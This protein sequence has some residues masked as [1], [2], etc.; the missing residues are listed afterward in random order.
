MKR[1]E[2][3]NNR[4]AAKIIEATKDDPI[5]KTTFEDVAKLDS[6]GNHRYT[7]WLCRIT[8]AKKLKLEDHYKVPKA[9]DSFK[10]FANLL[11]K[12]GLSTD[13]NAYENLS[14]VMSAVL[15]YEIMREEGDLVGKNEEL[16]QASE[17]ARSESVDFFESDQWRI[18]VP[19]T[20]E[21][22]V[23][24]GRSTRWCTAATESDNA[25]K[26]YYDGNR[27]FLYIFFDKKNNTK[28][29]YSN[30]D[31]NIADAAD[32]YMDFSDCIQQFID[33]V[34]FELFF[35][36]AFSDLEIGFIDMSV[37]QKSHMAFLASPLMTEI[38]KS[39]GQAG[40]AQFQELLSHYYDKCTA[41]DKL[42]L[43]TLFKKAI[44]NDTIGT[45][46]S[47]ACFFDSY[48]KTK[49]KIGD[50][51]DLNHLECLSAIAGSGW[52]IKDLSEEQME[53]DIDHVIV[54][55]NQKSVTDENEHAALAFLMSYIDE[56]ADG[57]FI[58]LVNESIVTQ[59]KKLQVAFD[60]VPAKQ[61]Q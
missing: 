33:T 18:V 2:F 9:L 43:N 31:S 14:K 8:I 16:R 49:T 11:K 12:D 34:D 56:A 3:L 38:V 45:V 6:S 10:H 1:I 7:D 26:S 59:A 55:M 36:E 50:D 52:S 17:K 13:I 40:E 51:Y 60:R 21:A 23:H 37:E 61:A 42:M 15:K 19:K 30:S 53:Y 39:R 57:Y 24:Y 22:S 29:Q 54:E 25:F 48:L 4:Y 58:N 32:E 28:F 5:Y 35:Q 44:K 27:K 20:E 41:V 46:V 47:C